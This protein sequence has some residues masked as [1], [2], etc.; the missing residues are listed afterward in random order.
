MNFV[1]NWITQLTADLS[2]GAVSLPISASALAQLGNGE[3]RLTLTDALSTAQQ[4]AWE[5]L[6]LQK[7]DGVATLA[8]GQENTAARYWPS[9]TVIY[10]AITAGILNQLFAQVENMAARLSALESGGSADGGLTADNGDQLTDQQ[11]NQL[12]GE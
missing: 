8:R 5:I 6:T 10:C 12:V 4:S 1:N 2:Q 3:Y 9:G 7:A 11:T